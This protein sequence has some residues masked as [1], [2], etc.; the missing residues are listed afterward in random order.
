[1]PEQKKTRRQQAEETKIHIF[2]SAL[3]LLDSKEFERITVRDIVKQADV[4]IGCFY[5][6]YSSKLDVYYETYQLADDYFEDIVAGRLEGLPFREAVLL[7]FDY[8]ARYSSEVTSLALTKVIYNSGNKCFERRRERG[9]FH[10]LTGVISAA[11]G[12]GELVSAET[13]SEIA[14]FF[15]L[16]VRGQTY[17]WCTC[18]GAYDLSEAMKGFAEKLLKVYVS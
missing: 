17:N 16:A 10:V 13:D 1:M 14:H 11:R 2:K 12:A 3:E 7:F 8:Y 15:M 18:D 5:N 9:M 4:S 6:Y